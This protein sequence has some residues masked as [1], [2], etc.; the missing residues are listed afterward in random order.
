MRKNWMIPMSAIL[1]VCS[2]CASD[3]GRQGTGTPLP[4]L[5]ITSSSIKSGELIPSR[6]TCS[7]ED[8]SPALAWQAAP[9]GT[10]SLALLV[11]DPDAPGGTFVHWVMYN[12][13]PGLTELKEGLAKEASLLDQ[14]TQGKNDFG[15][16]GYNG[17]CPPRGS[18]HHYYFHL[19]ALDIDA[20]LKAGL[21]GRAL[22][23]QID[24]HILAEG[25]FV[26][27]GSR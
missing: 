9:E 16:T 26:A 19:Y 20:Q 24:G 4:D 5:Q 7:G 14:G 21:D 17:P 13:P 25:T 11:E 6:Y 1:L 2:A 12:M 3:P 10:K 23:K 8:R 15:R 27:L 22:R 18:T